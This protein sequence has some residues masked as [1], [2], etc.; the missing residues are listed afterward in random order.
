MFNCF[1]QQQFEKLT[2]KEIQ[3]QVY[4]HGNLSAAVCKEW[5]TDMFQGLAYSKSVS[6]FINLMNF[7]I[8]KLLIINVKM[9]G[10]ETNSQ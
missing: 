8:K 6:L 4:T 9:I 3:K 1:C 5:V 2:Y 10:E 7:L